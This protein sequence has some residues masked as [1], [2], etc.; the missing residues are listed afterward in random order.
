MTSSNGNIFRVTGRLCREIIGH[1]WIPLTKAGDAELW[2]FLWCVPRINGWVNNR[3]AG[4]LR[5][6]RAHYDFIATIRHNCDRIQTLYNFLNLARICRSWQDIATNE[7]YNL[8]WFSYWINGF[9]LFVHTIQLGIHFQMT[10]S[11]ILFLT[12][13][14]LFV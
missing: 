2:C 4:D 8:M 10:N 12:N 13:V 7:T 6:Y 3:E 9:S 14:S 1:R 5:R 11:A